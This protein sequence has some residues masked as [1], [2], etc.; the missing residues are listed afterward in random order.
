MKSIIPQ[1]VIENKILLIRGKKVILDKDLAAFY[2]VETK[3]LNRAVKR[4]IDRFPEDFMFRLNKNEFDNLRFHFGT[5]SY[6]GRRYI[7]FVFTEQGVAMLSS[8]LKSKRAIQ[9]NIQIIR[10]FTRLR[11]IIISNRELRIKIEEME[12]K[13]ESKFKVIFDIIKKLIATREKEI[14]PNKRIG[15]KAK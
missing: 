7:P 8:V 6:G 9:A 11:E 1:E 4:N 2:Q 3:V 12:R 15:F 5:S 13:N 14:N 10:T